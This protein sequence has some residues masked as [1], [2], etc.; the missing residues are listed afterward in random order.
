MK[1]YI[2]LLTAAMYLLCGCN[3]IN[4]L[5]DKY[6]LDTES[7]GSYFNDATQLQTYTNV[8]YEKLFGGSIY[9]YESD[10]YFKKTLT[11]YQRG[12]TMRSLPSSGGG[13]D[14]GTLRHINTMFAHMDN[15]KDEGVRKEYTA[16]GRFFRAVYYFKMV[17]D[18]GDMPWIEKELSTVDEE[19]YYPRDNR[20]FVMDRMIEDLDAAIEGLPAAVTSPYRVNK[21]T[22]L[23]M[24]SRIML[25]EG[26]WRKYH[27][28]DAYKGD[29]KKSAD[30][31][32]NLAADAAYT[33][34]TESPYGIYS[35]GN[36]ELDY[37]VLFATQTANSRE[38]VLAKNF[39]L[40]MNYSHFASWFT[41]QD[42]GLS[43]NKKFIDSFLMKDGSRF[44]DKAGWETM[45]FYEQ[46]QDRDPRLAAIIRTPGY[47]R[48][49]SEITEG[50]TDI[51]YSDL[52]RVP[53][54]AATLSGYQVSK[55]DQGLSHC[56]DTWTATDGD[57]PLL[58]AAE[59]YLNYAEAKAELSDAGAL[60][61]ADL[62]MSIN[63]LR[64]RAGMPH[65]VKAD[66]NANPDNAYLGNSKYGYRN[67]T[68]ANK[69]VILEIRRE[70]TIELA[71]EGN[72][73]WYDL[74]RWKEGKCME[75]L[76]LGMYFPG[77][78]EYDLNHDGI[79]DICLYTGEKPSTECDQVFIIGKDV[80]LSNGE[81]GY[82]NYIEA[83]KVS[84]VFD[85]GRDYLEP[86]P[87]SELAVN[88]NLVQNPGWEKKK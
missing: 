56:P 76:Y 23:L 22:A 46:T 53:K 81:S 40:L 67:V 14:F 50:A 26:S 82:L 60:T 34:I 84:H 20:E 17:R 5:L 73:R 38:V 69:G 13:W 80:Y 72:L 61:Q 65:L 16:L 51:T 28:N 30:F 59:V 4:G 18:F 52:V 25:F 58:R 74:M 24:K 78:G 48:F 77:P 33:F 42:D 47:Q 57:L 2:I 85:E 71:Q 41:C 54:I 70:R 8:C 9:D 64:D 37:R 55:Y 45:Q 83:K 32:F 62:D 43:V 27:A 86:I 63:V 6:P 7:P 11:K 19:L 21:W 3:S 44:T 12:G 75:Q 66:A 79:M 29:W 15:C 88:T 39:S 49:S 87:T 10:L 35:T 1:K 68:G 36:P 31:Y